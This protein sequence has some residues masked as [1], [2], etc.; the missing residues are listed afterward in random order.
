MKLDTLTL[1]FI[2]EG[3]EPRR[4]SPALLDN[5]VAIK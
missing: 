1:K 4:E 2:G 3:K 5:S